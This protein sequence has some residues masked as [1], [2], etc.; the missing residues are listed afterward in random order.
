MQKGYGLKLKA[1]DYQ[2]WK[3]KLIRA[4]E[5]RYHAAVKRKRLEIAAADTISLLGVK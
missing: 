5:E 1:C 2:A 3:L 4:R